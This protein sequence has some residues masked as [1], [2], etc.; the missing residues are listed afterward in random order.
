MITDTTKHEIEFI[1]NLG[2]HNIHNE[3]YSGTK[4]KKTLLLGYLKG[5]EKREKWDGIDKKA[6]MAFAE[7]ALN[8]C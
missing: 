5:I 4:D 2:K 3:N 7:K 1:R 8:H 6:V